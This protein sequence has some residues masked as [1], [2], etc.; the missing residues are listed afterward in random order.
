MNFDYDFYNLVLSEISARI[1][2]DQIIIEKYLKNNEKSE[3]ARTSRAIKRNRINVMLLSEFIFVARYFTDG[4]IGT[5]NII[6]VIRLAEE[7]FLEAK[8][9][10]DKNRVKPL[11]NVIGDKKI[12]S[13]LFKILVG[14]T[15]LE[16]EKLKRLK[17][18]IRR[19]GDYATIKILGGSS[20]NQDLFLKDT[21]SL[22]STLFNYFGSTIRFTT[23][24]KKRLVFLRMHL[25]NQMPLL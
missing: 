19:R 20:L 17:L 21:A 23:Q 22:V 3:S 10:I 2:A 8:I 7:S 5:T 25:S 1:S 24:D 16:D 15:L 18:S 6:E 11:I 14:I 4:T 13:S 12:I 9:N